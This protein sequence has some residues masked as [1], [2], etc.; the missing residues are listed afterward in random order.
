MVVDD[1]VFIARVTSMVLE[2]N[3]YKTFTAANGNE[4]LALFNEHKKEIKIVLSDVMM[5]GMDGVELTRAL[6]A[7]D[8]QVKII[9]STGQAT[10]TRQ[11]ELRSLGVDVIL[12]KP[13]DAQRLLSVLHEVLHSESA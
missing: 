10:D 9:A 3:D 1:E 8:P 11:V 13:Y 12:R 4:A 7:I 6:K 5:P 2:K